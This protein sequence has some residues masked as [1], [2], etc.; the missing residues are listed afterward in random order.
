MLKSSEAT[1]ICFH[2]FIGDDLRDSFFS[3][4]IA[5]A[6]GQLAC[7]G[8]RGGVRRRRDSKEISDGTNEKGTDC[9]GGGFIPFA[10]PTRFPGVHPYSRGGFARVR[11]EERRVG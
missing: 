10:E 5:R 1:A 11:S 3:A 6:Q 4:R 7:G 9:A 8:S 2:V